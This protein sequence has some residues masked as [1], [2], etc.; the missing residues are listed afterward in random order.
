[1]PNLLIVDDEPDN[2]AVLRATLSDPSY[3]LFEALD[4]EQAWGILT[5]S[6]T[7]FNCMVLDR[8]MPRLDGMGLA[9]R[10][11]Q[12]EQFANLPIVMQTAAA[13]PEQVAEGLA[14][15]VFCYL[16]KPCDPTILRA[17]LRAALAQSDNWRALGDELTQQKS[18]SSML[19][20]ADFELRN[21]EQVRSLSAGI[22]AMAASPDAVSLGLH[23][24]LNN[25][26]EHGNL[27]LTYQDKSYFLVTDGWHAEVQRRLRLPE[28][29]GRRVRVQI[30]REGRV[31]S[32]TIEDDGKGFDWHRY[33]EI[34]PDRAYDL[35]GRG[36]ALARQVAFRTIEYLGCGNRVRV[37]FD[38]A[39]EKQAP[40][41]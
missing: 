2:L 36:I 8:M 13:E 7:H 29:S 5:E 40:G 12:S 16:T 23:E 6:G 15:G 39:G 1:M 25:A 30:E 27:E 3:R 31:A 32:L 26:I 9:R 18:F 24:L 34:D 10:M 35:H 11:K 38:T 22:G 14:L 20:R 19:T 28:Y 21:F 4:G 33:I 37:E 41:D 17:A